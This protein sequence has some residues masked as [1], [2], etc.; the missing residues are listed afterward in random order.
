MT[1]A[2]P[3]PARAGWFR[4]ARVPIS[5]TAVVVLANISAVIPALIALVPVLVLLIV[6]RVVGGGE[7]QGG[8]GLRSLTRA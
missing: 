7:A 8:I 5:I 2:A 4:S 6:R 1:G 3:T